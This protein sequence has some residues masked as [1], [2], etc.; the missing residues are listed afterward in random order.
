MD[1]IKTIFI[2]TS[3]FSI[4]I[5]DIL[6]KLEYLNLAAV[7]TQPDRPVGRRQILTPP[8]LKQHIIDTKFSVDI[9][10][11]E[12]LRKESKEIIEKY[13]PDLI[14]VA[15]YGQMVPQSML[16]Y[17]KYKCLN[18]HVSLLP[19]LRGAVPMPMAILEGLTQTGV[20]L[21]IMTKGLDEG[22]IISQ[23]VFDLDGTES[24]ELLEQKS[25]HASERLLHRDLQK[26]INGEITPAPQDH[27]QATYCTKEDVSK[28]KAEITFKTPVDIAERMIRAFYPWPVAWIIIPNGV[29]E[30]KRMK[31]FSAKVKNETRDM[32]QENSNETIYLFK[33]DGSLYLQLRD[34]ILELVEVQIEGKSKMEGRLVQL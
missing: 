12:I 27:G 4:G 15:S 23:E 20:A 32:K 21:Q 30:R 26:W 1:K 25:I 16:E 22:D 7:I 13:K 28:E 11:P 8:P 14:I 3:E 5:F 31:I 6:Q 24:T 10:Q 18:M 9:L 29:H 17:P 19:H 34:G 33:Q 2:G